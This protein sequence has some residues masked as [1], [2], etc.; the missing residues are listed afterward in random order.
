MHH[1]AL[2][3]LSRADVEESKRKDFYLYLDEFHTFTTLAFANMLSDLRKY[4]VGLILANQYLGQL[5]PE[6]RDSL[7][8]NVG[9]VI[10]F[11]LGPK[12]ARFFAEEFSPK[13]TAEDFINLPKFQIYL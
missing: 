5:E 9:T 13:I 12:D 3:G 7:I 6:V 1:I 4:R 11:R 10:L 2:S 8:G